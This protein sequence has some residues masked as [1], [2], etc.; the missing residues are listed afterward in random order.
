MRALPLV[1]FLSASVL[2]GYLWN[3]N[4]GL[5]VALGEVEGTV[6]EVASPE[7]GAVAQMKVDL[8]QSV[9]LDQPLAIIQAARP[10]VITNTLALIRAETELLKASLGPVIDRYRV[11]MDFERLRLDGMLH[12]ID[13]ATASTRLQYA[14][15]ELTRLQGLFDS[16]T[17]IVSAQTLDIAKRDRDVA[18]TEVEQKRE[19]AAA[20][21]NVAEHAGLPAS[22]TNAAP[23]L[24]P[25]RLAI[26]AEE[27]R[28]RLT[29]AQMA[30]LILRS[31]MNGLVTKILKRAGENITAGAVLLTISSIK[32]ERIVAYVRQPISIEPKVGMEVDIRT[33]TLPKQLARGK[34]LQ[35]ANR[36]ELFSAPMRM[37][38]L[39][40]TQERGLPF[41]VSKPANLKVHPGELVDVVL[42][43]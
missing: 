15:K 9:E 43:R 37:R 26:A 33:R 12:R 41:L 36:M 17:N 24:Q 8:Y 34:I 35:V 40:T 25:L 6:A 16:D 42:R 31:P 2:A 18:K 30:P 38:G 29:E 27:Q 3:Q 4:M 5:P 11:G 19:L 21:E 7:P 32:S 13:L 39:D 20:Y 14:E 28:L 23:D 22:W 1:V 10:E